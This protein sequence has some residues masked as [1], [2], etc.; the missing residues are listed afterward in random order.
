MRHYKNA[1]METWGFGGDAVKLRQCEVRLADNGEI[2]VSYRSSVDESGYTVYEGKELD[3]GH[4]LLECVSPVG[5]ASLH[6][7]PGSLI[8][9]GYFEE[10]ETQ[11]MWRV[12]LGEVS[13][14]VTGEDAVEHDDWSDVDAV[15]ELELPSDDGDD[16]RTSSARSYRFP[17]R[18][19]WDVYLR[20]PTDLT[21]REGKRLAAFIKS[22]AC[23]EY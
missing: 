6:R 16:D 13:D 15:D 14:T 5:R 10:G 3:E 4:Y 17:L 22:L 8:L 9:E 1:T 11:G 7:F 20:I 18:N 19:D 2:E 12:T 21:R 23:Y